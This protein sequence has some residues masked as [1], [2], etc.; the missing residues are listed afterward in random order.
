MELTEQEIREGKAALDK[1]MGE[2]ITWRID[3]SYHNSYDWLMPVWV[4]FRD[5]PAFNS[6][7]PNVI[8]GQFESKVEYAV[9]YKPIS[10]AFRALVSAVKWYDS[11]EK[12]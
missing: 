9:V 8:K 11:I 2:E 7:M 6:C 3:V 4:K 12:K 1:F 5:I 10:E